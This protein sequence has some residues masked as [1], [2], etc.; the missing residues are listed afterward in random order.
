MIGSP[1]SF[2]SG[3]TGNLAFEIVAPFGAVGSL[4]PGGSFSM[5]VLCLVLECLEYF[6][7][8]V[9]DGHHPSPPLYFYKWGNL[10]PI[11]ISLPLVL[12]W[13]GVCQLLGLWLY[14]YGGI[15]SR[16]RRDWPVLPQLK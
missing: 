4:E 14:L 16:Y 12:Q 9:L 13:H 2:V 6:A 5:V 8:F 10:V 3:G 11:H 1:G 7:E 15:L